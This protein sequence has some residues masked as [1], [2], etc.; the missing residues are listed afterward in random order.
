MSFQ[1]KNNKKIKKIITLKNETVVNIS[2][3]KKKL[4]KIDVT[5]YQLSCF[6]MI[7]GCNFKAAFPPTLAFYVLSNMLA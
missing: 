1:L 5:L 6:S 4:L 3:L 7:L 2:N